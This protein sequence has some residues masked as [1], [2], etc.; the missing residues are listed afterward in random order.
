MLTWTSHHSYCY[1]G[2]TSCNSY[3]CIKQTGWVKVA[4][5]CSYLFRDSFPAD[6][7]F[8]SSGASWI[9]I[10]LLKSNIKI[11]TYMFCVFKWNR[12]KVGTQSVFSSYISW[13]KAV[14]PP[15]DFDVLTFVL[16]LSWSFLVIIYINYWRRLMDSTHPSEY[17]Y[18][19]MSDR[20]LLYRIGEWGKLHK[21]RCVDK[22]QSIYCLFNLSCFGRRR[23]D[24]IKFFE[25]VCPL[26]FKL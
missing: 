4:E 22:N 12:T 9:R 21:A 1:R 6:H 5:I 3:I 17:K 16:C 15:R 25:E 20:K 10:A 14:K 26:V 8:T 19:C 7:C 2:K 23:L 24:L 18:V 13:V 11:F